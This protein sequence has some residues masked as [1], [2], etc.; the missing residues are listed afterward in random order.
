MSRAYNYLVVC[1]TEVSCR[2]SVGSNGGG[3]PRA[4]HGSKRSHLTWCIKQLA[5][6]D[7]MMRNCLNLTVAKSLHN[8]TC[9][10]CT[11]GQ[12][13]GCFF[14]EGTLISRLCEIEIRNNDDEQINCCVLCFSK[15]HFWIIRAIEIR[16]HT[17]LHILKNIAHRLFSHHHSSFPY[18]LFLF[19]TGIAYYLSS[20]PLSPPSSYNVS[21]TTTKE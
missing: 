19:H 4:A 12:K 5:P 3:I 17:Y 21:I 13:I 7:S 20:V 1:I 15:I 6:I 2:Q 14:E 16:I 10:A 18:S 9:L 11:L 8:D